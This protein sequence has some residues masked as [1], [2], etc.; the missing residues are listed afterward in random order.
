MGT[1]I[2]GGSVLPS[3]T[4]LALAGHFQTW[5]VPRHCHALVIE[6]YYQ[7]DACKCGLRHLT[8][9]CCT[10]FLFQAV[11]KPDKESKLQP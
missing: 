2:M 7:S 1:G 9:T 8:V 4:F 10:P 3:S 11:K 5:Y 6:R